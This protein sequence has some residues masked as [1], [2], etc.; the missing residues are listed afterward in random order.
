[1]CPRADA[2][3]GSLVAQLKLHWM[4]RSTDRGFRSGG[5]SG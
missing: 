3:R 5:L 4:M 2:S 1:V